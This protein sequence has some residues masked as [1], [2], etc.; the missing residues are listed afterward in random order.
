MVY[1]Q[2]FRAWGQ[3]VG[4]NSTSMDFLLEALL[5]IQVPFCNTLTIDVMKVVN[6]SI[7]LSLRPF[8]MN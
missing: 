1:H 2:L 4:A 3:T 5:E 6:F 8:V 7:P